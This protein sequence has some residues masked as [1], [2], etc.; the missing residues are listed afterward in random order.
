MYN[1]TLF[2]LATDVFMKEHFIMYEQFGM[3]QCL[4]ANKLFLEH[5][6]NGHFFAVTVLN[7][8]FDAK[9]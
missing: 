3:L 6:K 4:L 8:A 5:M 9:Y 1:S 2:S 7:S